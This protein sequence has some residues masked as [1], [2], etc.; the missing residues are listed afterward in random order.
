MGAFCSVNTSFAW[1][2]VIVCD[3]HSEQCAQSTV[4][5]F[6][7]FTMNRKYNQ[8]D[9]PGYGLQTLLSQVGV[10]M[11]P[12]AGRC[13]I[14]L[15]TVQPTHASC[16]CVQHAF[17]FTNV[18][19][20]VLHDSTIIGEF[21]SQLLWCAFQGLHLETGTVRGQ[22]TYGACPLRP[23]SARVYYATSLALLPS[24]HCV[25]PVIYLMCVSACVRA[26]VQVCSVCK[27]AFM[28]V[29]HQ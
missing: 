1:V 5:H 9:S 27:D 3:V 24:P 19:R 22:V 29:L 15:A 2:R 10:G 8:P 21:F 17:R 23:L 6:V 4:V 12:V 11:T 28:G 26:C 18:N 7:H 16:S 13:S 20:Y 14:F 25:G